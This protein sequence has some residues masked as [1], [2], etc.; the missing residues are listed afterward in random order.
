MLD[1]EFAVVALASTSKLS[2][3]ALPDDAIYSILKQI[4]SSNEVQKLKGVSKKFRRI[5]HN[6]GYGLARPK[7][8]SMM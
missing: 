4:K 7:I 3:N 8:D 5:I 2:I 6:R 1:S